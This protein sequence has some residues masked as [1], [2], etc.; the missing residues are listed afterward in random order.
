MSPPSQWAL[1]VA[2]VS[3]A[4]G[5]SV[6]TIRRLIHA[7]QLPSVRIGGQYRV[8]VAAIEAL[9]RSAEDPDLPP[10]A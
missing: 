2:D 10:A 5:L 9:L 4:L 8:P 3:V 6:Q 7:G 1:S